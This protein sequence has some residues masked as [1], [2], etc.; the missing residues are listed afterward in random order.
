MPVGRTLLAA[1]LAL[2]LV[3]A[4]CGREEQ[5]LR[6]A[7]ALADESAVAALVNDEPI[8]VSDVLLQAEAQGIASPGGEGL[9]VDSAEFNRVLDQLIDVRLLA[10]E[11]RARE[12]DKDPE[13]Q[14]RLQAARDRILGDILIDETVA[15]RIDEAAIRRMYDQQVE[16]MVL[17]DEAR[18]RHILALS[19]PEIDAVA[20]KLRTGVDFAVLAAQTSA[21]AVTRMEGGDLGYLKEAEAT[22]EFAR[23]LRATATGGVSKPFETQEGWHVIKVE[24]RRREQPPSIEELRPLILE[25]LS[26]MQLDDTLKSLRQKARI[27][28]STSAQNQP[29]EIDPF[30]IAPEGAEPRGPAAPLPDSRDAPPPSTAPAAPAPEQP[31]APLPVPPPSV[32]SPAAAPPAGAPPAGPRPAPASPAA[33]ASPVAPLGETRESAP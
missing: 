16:R 4:G 7:A 17:G 29:L 2:C 5:P 1:T 28:R 12:L 19:K 15:E 25:H 14:M 31:P 18:V 11:A 21:D 30:A 24:E 13:V 6:S 26:L 10:I 22:P 23:A 8:Y 9:E 27:E 20:A 32:S 3:P 33:P